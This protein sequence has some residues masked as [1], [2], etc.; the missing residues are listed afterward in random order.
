[1]LTYIF[2]WQLIKFDNMFG[3]NF[4]QS[5]I[6]FQFSNIPGLWTIFYSFELLLYLY[7]P[8]PSMQWTKYDT[9]DTKNALFVL[10]SKTSLWSTMSNLPKCSSVSV[11]D[12][13]TSSIS[14]YTTL[15]YLWKIPGAQYGKQLYLYKP[16]WVFI[17][18]LNA[19][20]FDSL[21]KGTWR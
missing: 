9:D 18:I 12:I 3:G 15:H 16:L 4:E 14:K 13:K 2:V 21:F 7:S 11:T 5:K 1:M 20:L 19:N 17:I 6:T 10:E 8:S